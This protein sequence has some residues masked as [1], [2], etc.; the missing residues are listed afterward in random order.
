MAG[1]VRPQ[2]AHHR[3]KHCFAEKALHV[4]VSLALLPLV[5]VLLLGLADALLITR[6][7]AA[8]SRFLGLKLGFSIYFSCFHKLFRNEVGRRRQNSGVANS[9][10]QQG[11]S[12]TVGATLAFWRCAVH[13]PW[14][15]ALPGAL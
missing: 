10:Y 6:A 13:R 2:R 8:L 12:P 9:F 5:P 3:R 4:L 14:R 7:H 1:G 15:R 11:R